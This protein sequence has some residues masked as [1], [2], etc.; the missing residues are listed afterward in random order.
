MIN[1]I[2]SEGS[3]DELLMVDESFAYSNGPGCNEINKILI[4]MRIKLFLNR[5]SYKSWGF[6]CNQREISANCISGL[7]E[8]IYRSMDQVELRVRHPNSP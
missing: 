6:P 7:L 2:G 1:L 4:G 5:Q 3:N 8:E